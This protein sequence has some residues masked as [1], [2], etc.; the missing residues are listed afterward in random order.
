MTGVEGLGGVV[1]LAA[2][3]YDPRSPAGRRRWLAARRAGLGASDTSA[4]LGLNPYKSALQVWFEKRAGR[5]DDAGEAAAWGNEFEHTVAR[6]TAKRFPELGKLSPTPGI[7]AHP[8]H[9]WMLA[10]VDRVLVERGSRTGGR[11][12]GLLEVKTVNGRTYRRQWVDGVP[13]TWVQVQVQ[14]QLAVTGLDR[15]WVACL[16][17]GQRLQDPYPIDRHAGVFSSIVEYAGGW[18]ADHV[19][20][21]PLGRPEPTLAD[22]ARLAELWGGDLELDAITATP[23]LLET[24]ARLLDARRRRG[25]VEDEIERHEFQIKAA[26]REHTAIREPGGDVLATWKPTT[27][28]RVDVKLLRAEAPEVAE[29]FTTAKPGRRFDVKAKA[30]DE[31]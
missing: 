17:D 6:V 8:D 13:P 2:A 1:V 18:W 15:C 7:L 9:P 11:A 27:T 4:V 29:R 10:T 14:Q 20:P 28:R 5:D 19:D 25:E 31:G 21:G 24:F 30:E 16:V 12:V 23:D 3:E 26:L 22:H